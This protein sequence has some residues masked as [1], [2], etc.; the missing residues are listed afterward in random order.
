[1][2]MD[3]IWTAVAFFL[4]LLTLSYLLGDNP[5]F[6]IVTYLFIGVSAAYVAI[7]LL[8]QVLLPRLVAPLIFGSASEKLLTIFPAILSVLLLFKLFPRFSVLGNPSMAFLVG[9]GASVIIT[10]AITGTLFG[11]IRGAIQP[12]GLMQAP[13]A[14]QA[15]SQLIGSIIL[16]VGTISTLIFFQFSARRNANQQ[17]GRAGVIQLVAGT[18][19]VFIGI[20]LGA[21]FAGVL[22]AALT[23][24]IERFDF[25]RV[26]L[27]SL[28]P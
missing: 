4:T 21:L 17:V 27:Q 7:I 24:L 15:S 25:L 11:Q 16:L 6:R 19:Q 26:A 3:L 23:A 14:I 8:S 28:L 20:T 10:G 5:L 9:I 13:D 12:F 22:A 2:D 1:M 18:G